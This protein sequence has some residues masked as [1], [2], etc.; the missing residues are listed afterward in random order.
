MRLGINRPRTT[1]ASSRTPSARPAPSSCSPATR[2]A[3]SP[4]RAPTMMSAAALTTR[5]VWARPSVT[6]RALSCERSQRLAHAGDEEH[7]VVHGQPE[8]HGE[9]EDR[10]P[11]LDLDDAVK[12]E[13]VGA[14]A[15][16]KDEDQKTVGGSDRD[17]IEQ[18]ADE[19]QEQG[20]E[21]KEQHQ[22]GKCQDD[23]D[24]E[25]EAPVGPPEKIHALRGRAP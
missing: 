15:E 2:P 12:A 17:H 18:H 14:D 1:V 6:A 16:A 5:P 23:E 25:G 20:T 21:G 24:D 11:A 3:T 9:K 10:H 19:R 8:Q 13:Q 4:E 22:V 7:L